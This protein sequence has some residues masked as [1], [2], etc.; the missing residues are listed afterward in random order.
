[1]LSATA[2]VVFLLDESASIVIEPHWVAG[3]VT[4]LDNQLSQEGITNNRYG[5]VGFAASTLTEPL[6]GSHVA[7]Q[8]LSVGP[9]RGPYFRRQY[10]AYWTSADPRGPANQ[11]TNQRTAAQPPLSSVANRVV[12]CRAQTP[13]R[14]ASAPAA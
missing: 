4:E 2:D 14:S 1:M 9:G 13:S 10:S 11:N 6:G 12:C 8:A 5:L 3:V 7:L